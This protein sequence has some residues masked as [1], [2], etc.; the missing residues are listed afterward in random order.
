MSTTPR[1]YA[2]DS[3]RAILMM[4]GIVVHAA[5]SYGDAP[6]Q[7]WEYETPDASYAIFVLADVIHSFRMPLFFLIS[8]FFGALLFYQKGPDYMLKNR[9]QRILLPFLV[10]LFLLFPFIT[11]SF[12][13]GKEA[14]NRGEFISWQSFFSD[15]DHYLPSQLIHLWFLYYLFIIS[16]ITYALMKWIYPLIKTK[17]HINMGTLFNH[18]WMGLLS[19]TTTCWLILFIAEIPAFETSTQ[20]VPKWSPLLYNAIFYWYGWNLFIKKETI[21]NYSKHWIIFSIIG[22]IFQIIKLIYLSESSYEFMQVVSSIATCFLCMGIFGFFFQ[23]GNFTNRTIQYGVSSAYW[24]Y[25]MH[26]IPTV[27]IPIWLKDL[28]ISVHIKFLITV[29]S[30][31]FFCLAT[32]EI[33]VRKTFIGSFLSGRAINNKK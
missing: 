16:A 19:L 1:Y 15:I 3:L 5:G 17:I 27:V 23:Y 30:T 8:G 18:P 21:N 28:T 25:L 7:N 12:T 10:F 9:I 24:V 31:L 11:Y 33:F 32:F 2:F 20:W 6:Y 13:L 22:L 14:F 4:L 29:S 26:F